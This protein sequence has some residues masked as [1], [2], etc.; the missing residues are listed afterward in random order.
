[1]DVT[2]AA[3]SVYH[4]LAVQGTVSGA[5]PSLVQDAGGV[6]DGQLGCPSGRSGILNVTIFTLC[7]GWG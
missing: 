3:I 7:L 5:L 2:T 1:M 4:P 6:I